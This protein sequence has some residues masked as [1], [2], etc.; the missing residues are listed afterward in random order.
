MQPTD[1]VCHLLNPGLGVDGKEKH[2]MEQAE[3][4]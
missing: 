2:G 3:A 4:I 1:T